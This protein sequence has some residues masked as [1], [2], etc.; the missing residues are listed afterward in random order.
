MSR[1]RGERAI[2]RVWSKSNGN[3][4][5]VTADPITIR[6]QRPISSRRTRTEWGG[7]TYWQPLLLLSLV[8]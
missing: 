2:D 7:G 5:P 4:L 8:K 1:G 3:H 6:S